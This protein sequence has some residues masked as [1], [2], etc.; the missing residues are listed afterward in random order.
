[1]RWAT[2]PRRPH[3][4]RLASVESY[5]VIAILLVI[6][7]HSNF[8]GRLHLAGGEYGYLVD[9]PLYMVFWISVPFF[10]LVAGYFYGTRVNAGHDPMAL[11]RAYAGPLLL[12]F[13]IW[14]LVYAVLPR[15]WWLAMHQNGIWATLSSEAMQTLAVLK[16]EHIMLLLIPRPPIYH[17]WFLPTLLL[18]LAT[19]AGVIACRLEKAVFGLI[20]GFYG[21]A[22]AAELSP[23]AF[24]Q[25]NPPGS[26]LLA[27]LCTLLGWWI[28]QRK[29]VSAPLAL[30]LMAG[31][32]VLAFTEGAVLKLAW[33]A[34]SKDVAWHT[35]GGGILMVTGIFL[36][37]LA[38]PDLGKGTILPSLAR[39]TLGVYVSH[40]LVE[41]TLAP[42]LATV[43]RP[44]SVV[45]HFVYAM[46]V[47]GLSVALTFLLSHLPFTRYAVIREP[48][49]EAPMD[50]RLPLHPA[51]VAQ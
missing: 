10:F 9:L 44:L 37:T 46:A 19:V 7:L 48:R 28:A 45:W 12:V 24:F 13:G 1:M 39:F 25:S 34:S 16:S 51:R 4:A 8:I 27:M 35:Y 15:N 29:Q 32:L 11:L 2:I 38:K 49:A 26:L 43:P 6:F 47:Y 36:F 14:V 40:M 22:V 42:F 17:L 23:S 3:S 18:G 41:N 20:I 33:H 50:A 21:L 31:G 30:W 5:R